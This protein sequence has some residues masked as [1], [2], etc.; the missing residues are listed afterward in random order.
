MKFVGSIAGLLIGVLLAGCD[1]GENASPNTLNTAPI[2]YPTVDDSFLSAIDWRF[3]GPYRGGRV[4]AV[5]GTLDDPFVYY[6]GAA[7]GGV[8]KTTDAGMNWRNVSDDFFE[9]PAVGALDVSFSNSD[10]IYVGTGEGVQRQFISPGDGVY[11]SVDGGETW[12]NVGL[13]ETRHIAR[14]RI[15]P[16]DPDIVFVAA[17]GDMFGPNPERGIYRTR[18][19]GQTWEQVLYKGDSTGGVDLTM[20]PDYPDVIFAS[21]NHHVTYPWD[22]ESGGPT[23]GLFKSTD[24]GDTWTDITHNPGMPKG[25]VG[26]ICVSISPARGSRVYAFIEADGGE[27][28]IYRSDD[29]GS[30]WHRT[31]YDPGKMEIPNS[32]NYITADTQ[33]PD[34][35]YIQPIVGLLKSTDAGVTFKEVE[36]P[37]WDPHALWIDPNNSRRMI[38]GGD[39]GASV[40]MNGGESWSSLNNQPTADL[41]SLAVDDQ[42]PYWV[43]A[44]QNDNSHIAIPSQTDDPSIDRT[45]YIPLPAGEGGQTAVTPDGSVIYA[46]DRSRTV[47]IDRET[48]EAP[49][50][51]VWPEWVF[52]TAMKD[53]HLRFY[54]S[55]PILRSSHGS[56]ALYTAAQYVFRSTDEGQTWEQISADLTRNRREVMDEISGGPISSNAS[57]LFHSSVIRT[58]AESPLTEGELWVGT[59]DSNVQLSQDDGQTWQDVSP[60]DLPEWTT[61]TSI[62]VSHHHL[63]T[64]YISGERHRV[65]DRTTY[66]YKTTDYGDTWQ[67]ITDGIHAN[68]F[69]WVVREDPVR[70]GLLYAGTET[71]AYISFDDGDNW[72]PLNGNLPAV[73]V[74]QMQVKDDDLVVAT[75]GRGIWILDNI[76]ALRGITLDV[77]SAPVHLF[78]VAPA[79]RHLRGGRGWSG[80][81]SGAKNPTRGVTFDYYLA[82]AANDPVTVTITETSG[83]IIKTFSS[84]T[85]DSPSAEVGMNR[86]FWNMRYPGTVMP[87]PNGALDGFMSVDY[88]PPSSP[89]A[90]PGQYK[91]QLTVDGKTF[92][93]PFEIRKDPRI[94]ASDADLR[95]QFDLMVDI[96]D[97]FTEVSDTVLRIREIRARFNERRAN[98]PESFADSADAILQE[99]RDI[100]GTLMIWMGSPEHPMMWSSPGLTEKLSSLSSTVL[101]GDARPTPSMVAVF[102]DLTER[103]ELQRTRLNKIIDQELAPSQ[104]G[105][106]ER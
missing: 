44:A 37:N 16:T 25:M 6:F 99:L 47:R 106:Q 31:H 101:S 40:T 87:P 59:D 57:S 27:G 43:Y 98:L 83:E 96:R 52:G 54:Y 1:S 63:G 34:V 15:H 79:L 75:H 76:S 70:P 26:K 80:L 100:E 82:N 5:A 17:M 29:G 49:Q 13:K 35:V 84:D 92:K 95:A 104:S 23:S 42:E 68:D 46:N 21:M 64:A 93:Q 48:G 62:D 19:G 32:Y 56:H 10:V 86:F 77:A 9:F 30:T 38:E 103:Y 66:L 41:L 81:V 74:M 4:L 69:S 24:G 94:K 67:R 105:E 36:L 28:G 11:K 51:S 3:I 33:N 8:W 55:F 90:A 14:I 102:A 89:V 71:G 7:H 91:V 20:D 60:P 85:G 18:D 72:Q 58:L 22:E 53:F 12:T 39:G 78:E 45:H 97:R 88:S 61:I 65:S 50:I 73:L 2:A